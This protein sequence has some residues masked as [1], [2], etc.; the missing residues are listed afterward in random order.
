MWGAQL[1]LTVF[2]LLWAV[3]T[4]LEAHFASTVVSEKELKTSS[5]VLM[6]N[7]DLSQCYLFHPTT[8][9]LLY[10]A[11]KVGEDQYKLSAVTLKSSLS[12]SSGDGNFHLDMHDS[13][14]LT[15]VYRCGKTE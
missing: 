6:Y 9:D 1:V 2:H 7:K 14:D 13:A 12:G 3:S 4:S 8:N 10:L 15:A 5:L 11:L